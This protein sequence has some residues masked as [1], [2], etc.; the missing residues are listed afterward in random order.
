VVRFGILD[1]IKELPE[2]ERFN[3]AVEFFRSA[4][5]KGKVVG[6][7]MDL[8]AMD[9]PDCLLCEGVAGKRPCCSHYAG[10]VRSL[11]DWVF[12][13]GKYLARET[14]CKATGHETRLFELEAR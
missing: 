4:I 10:C 3:R 9:V 1:S 13:K 11:S 8:A 7:A 14:H 5:N 6:G 2:P 12:S